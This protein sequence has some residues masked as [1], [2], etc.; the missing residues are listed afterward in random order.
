MPILTLT[1]VCHLIGG[2]SALTN[3]CRGRHCA[4]SHISVIFQETCAQ[5]YRGVST[6]LSFPGFRCFHRRDQACGSSRHPITIQLTPICSPKQLVD[7]EIP[8]VI[9]GKPIVDCQPDCL[10][11]SGWS[12]H[13]ERRTH[14]G[15]TSEIVAQKVRAA[16]NNNLKVILCIGETLTE[17]EAGTTSQV[18]QK[19]LEAVLKVTEKSDWRSVEINVIIPVIL[20]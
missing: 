2:R 14:F 18:V 20:I 9:L 10:R 16:L 3:P 8:Y 11:L 15:E 19:Q 17:R 6:E 5:R 7:A 13:S 4:P 12:G 1:Q